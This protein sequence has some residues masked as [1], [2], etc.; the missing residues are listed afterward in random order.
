MVVYFKILSQYWYWGTEENHKKNCQVA[1]LP[2]G[3]RSRNFLNK[4]QGCWPLNRD[5]QF[6]QFLTLNCWAR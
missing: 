2:V 1:G 5:A 3:I 6:S 4:Q